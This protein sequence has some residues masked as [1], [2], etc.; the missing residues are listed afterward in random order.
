MGNHGDSKKSPSAWA[1]ALEAKLSG[2]LDDL[3]ARDDRTAT[4][5]T[6]IRRTAKSQLNFSASA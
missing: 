1:K 3:M 4:T 5:L 6:D 2:K